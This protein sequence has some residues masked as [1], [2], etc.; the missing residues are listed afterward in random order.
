LE[1][2]VFLDYWLASKGVKEG[3]KIAI[4]SLN[5]YE[6]F[7]AAGAVEGGWGGIQRGIIWLTLIYY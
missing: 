1:I 3:I 2:V 5:P 4:S 6:G 7:G